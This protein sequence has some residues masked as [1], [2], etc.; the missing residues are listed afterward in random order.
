MSLG[1]VIYI[2]PGISWNFKDQ[3]LI[4]VPK[5][6]YDKEGH[7]ITRYWGGGKHK[8]LSDSICHKSNIPD[9]KL[10]SSV[11]PGV[12]FKLPHLVNNF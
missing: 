3:N 9:E 11:L 6:K 12:L 10:D 5:I 2:S 7:F 1:Q 4:F 8:F